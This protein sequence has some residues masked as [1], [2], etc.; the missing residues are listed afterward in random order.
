MRGFDY[1]QF[2]SNV[3][4]GLALAE[5]LGIE[6]AAAI[7]GMWKSVPDIGV[8]TLHR[9]NVR[10]KDILWVPLFA[11]NDR[12][13]VVLT[14]EMLRVRYREDDAV[15]GILNNRWDRGR[16]AELFAR[17]VP[18]DLAG[19]LHHVITFGAYEEQVTGQMTE[20]GYP[21][22]RIT[23]LGET[24]HPTIDQI[25]DTIAGLVPGERGVL[26]GMVNIH[27]HQAEM[28]LEYFEHERGSAHTS[29]LEMSR[30]PRRMPLPTQR[31]RR[32]MAHAR[33]RPRDPLAAGEGARPVPDVRGRC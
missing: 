11:A 18:M 13:S 15:I 10:G 32:A 9:Y 2:K 23:N 5:L 21:R 30:D 6:R 25:L 4:I 19:Y 7:R 14:F 22:E 12:E 16:R 33:S 17:M 20:L 26:I 27:T 29:E 31:F 3:A 28:L 24:V 8:V 1:L